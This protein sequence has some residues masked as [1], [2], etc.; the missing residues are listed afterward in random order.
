MHANDHKR[1]CEEREGEERLGRA[2]GDSVDL[3]MEEVTVN[4][5]GHI[6]CGKHL[7]SWKNHTSSV[8]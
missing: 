6:D 3:S 5:V 7:A 4:K 8:N 2:H 1:E